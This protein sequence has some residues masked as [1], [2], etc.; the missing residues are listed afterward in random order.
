M[1]AVF[2]NI[3]SLTITFRVVP[4]DGGSFGIFL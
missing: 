3:S 4:I 2:E 1:V